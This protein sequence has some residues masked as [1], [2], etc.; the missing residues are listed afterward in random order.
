MECVYWDLVQTNELCNNLCFTSW[1]LMT[2]LP[3]FWLKMV[4]WEFL[5][6][7]GHWLQMLESGVWEK[8]ET[9]DIYISFCTYKLYYGSLLCPGLTSL[10]ATH[11]QTLIIPYTQLIHLLLRSFFNTHSPYLIHT[12]SCHLSY[13]HSVTLSHTHIH[14]Y[15]S[16][17]TP[18]LFFILRPFQESWQIKSSRFSLINQAVN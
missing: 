7:P 1:L 5:D 16:T 15:S 10:S 14:S 17:Q 18:T 11:T 8:G 2:M 9:S 12:F 4:G 6:V 3:T 13:M